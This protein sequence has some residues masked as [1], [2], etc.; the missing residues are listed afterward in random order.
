MHI[1]LIN[2]A[3]LHAGLIRREFLSID[4]CPCHHSYVFGVTGHEGLS[5]T[6]NVL[7]FFYQGIIEMKYGISRLESISR[8]S[9]VMSVL[10][11]EFIQN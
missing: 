5:D 1:Q 9:R 4:Y 8:G 10:M 7:I 11:V 3:K 6:V 2:S